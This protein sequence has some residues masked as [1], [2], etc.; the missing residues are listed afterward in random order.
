MTRP[1]WWSQRFAAEGGA[2]AEGISKQLGRP[3]MDPLTILLRE[4]AQNSWDARRPDSVVEYRIQIRTLGADAEAWRRLLLPGPMGGRQDA[5]LNDALCP[6]RFLI[7]ISDRGTRGLGGPLRADERSPDGVVPNFVQFLRNVGEPSDQE[8]GGGTYGFGKGILYGVSSAHTILVSTHCLDG[9]GHDRRLMAASLAHSFYEA[10]VRYTGR[11]WWGDCKDDVPDPITDDAAV[12]HARTLSLPEFDQQTGTDIVII[13]ADLGLETGVDGDEVPRTPQQAG[14][15]LASSILWNLWPK[16]GSEVRP[17]SMRFLV[18]VDGQ[19]IAM[20][21]PSSV[22]RLRDF[23]HALDAIHQGDAR[24]YERSRQ[25]LHGGDINVRTCASDPNLGRDAGRVVDSA[26]PFSAPYRHIARMRAA[27][28]VVDYFEGNEHPDPLLGY[29][30][31]FLASHEADAAFAASEP[32]TH[33]DW[34]DRGLAGSQ[35]GVVQGSRKFI[36]GSIADHLPQAIGSGATLAGLGRFASQLAG[37]AS[38]SGLGVG[39]TART[40]TD[41][42][43]RD[44]VPGRNDTPD[45][46]GRGR[47]SGRPS[48]VR[49]PDIRIHDGVPMIVAHV[50]MPSSPTPCRL[51]LRPH[52]VLEGG[53]RESEPPMGETAPHV[54]GWWRLNEPQWASR[55]AALHVTPHPTEQ[56]F[57]VAVAYM[58]DVTVR[59]ELESEDL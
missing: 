56:V 1:T 13:G 9:L 47:R 52:V 33:D 19:K 27:E 57:G 59:F 49:G 48:I 2:A 29:A 3:P 17:E 58:A 28:L 36:R 30:G 22:P 37:L 12:E 20:P 21:A 7:T 44:G 46:S 34:V 11:H 43:D 53:G 41:A 40:S 24:R 42:D 23:V 51:V 25:P 8:F 18:E 55:E 6:G 38:A 10:D 14:E 50:L 5:G 15:F 45:R 16:L 35:R 4:S 31:V 39:G 54:L 32:P 26:A